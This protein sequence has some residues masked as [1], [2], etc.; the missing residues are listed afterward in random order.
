[1][2]QNTYQTGKIAEDLACK[3]LNQQGLRLLTRNYRTPGGEIDLIMQDGETIVF[4]EVRSRKNNKTMH[5]VESINT[6]KCARII[7]ASQ[8]YL[9][10]KKHGSDNLCRFDVVL[11]IGR[12]EDAKVEW[13]KNAF[14]A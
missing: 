2:Q 14:E 12:L 13:I 1:M 8:Q 4:I 9:Q 11:V 6:E 3:Y 10:R 7:R 5:V